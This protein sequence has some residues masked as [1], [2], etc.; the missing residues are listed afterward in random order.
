MLLDR[1]ICL[2]FHEYRYIPI[3][4][5]LKVATFRNNVDYIFWLLF[6][7]LFLHRLEVVKMNL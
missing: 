1:L 5:L 4:Y 7:P 2:V 6:V 3:F